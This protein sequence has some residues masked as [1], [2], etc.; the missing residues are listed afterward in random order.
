M[1]TIRRKLLQ[2]AVAGVIALLLTGMAFGEVIPG[3][4]DTYIKQS[5]P[6]F[7]QHSQ[8]WCWAA[9]AANSFWW[10][11][12]NGYP[13]LLDDPGL[14]AG[15]Q[16]YKNIDPLSLPAG[17]PEWRDTDPVGYRRL[18]RELAIDGGRQFSQANSNNG[19]A[20]M[21]QTYINDQGVGLGSITHPT[22]Y[23]LVHEL[24]D[25]GFS[26]GNDRFGPG[27]FI[28]PD[29]MFEEYGP[30]PPIVPL[31]PLVQQTVSSPT[32]ADIARELSRSQDVMLGV[33]WKRADGSFDGGHVVTVAGYDLLNNK[34]TISDPYTDAGGT[35]ATGP[36]HRNSELHPPGQYDTWNV[37]S[38]LGAPLTVE[39]PA[40]GNL[41]AHPVMKMWFVSP[42]PEPGMICLLG[43]GWL[44]LC[45]RRK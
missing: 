12:H 26:A 34:L 4:P 28:N 14:P 42:V 44:V 19:I 18:L 2:T 20:N 41:R 27:T 25:P 21:L 43:L 35:Y 36:S 6:D 32:L 23:L 13:E 38:A 8:N 17:P 22:D 7:G 15:N 37:T 3:V 40:S 16:D 1:E 33:I 30:A 39:V 24:V 31:D 10:Y 9:S 11:A 45:R 5:M 29:D